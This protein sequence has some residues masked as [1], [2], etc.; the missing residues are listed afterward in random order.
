MVPDFSFDMHL[1]SCDWLELMVIHSNHLIFE[2]L[3]LGSVR[4]GEIHFIC[5][6]NK[7]LLSHPFMPTTTLLSRRYSTVKQSDKEK[8]VNKICKDALV[9]TFF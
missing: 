6:F 9:T 7:Y 2:D 1:Y 3:L 4:D 8:A 5:S